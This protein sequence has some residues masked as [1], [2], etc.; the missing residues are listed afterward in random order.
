MA[1]PID[2]FRCTLINS[3]LLAVSDSEVKALIDGAFN[4]LLDGN[5]NGFVIIRFAD[6]TLLNLSQFSADNFN[7][8]Q[9]LNICVAKESISNKKI[10]L[11]TKVQLDVLF[12]G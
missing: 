5:V 1:Q 11:Q 2:D 7:N 4:K 8:R 6:K 3:T 12:A 9:W 10:F